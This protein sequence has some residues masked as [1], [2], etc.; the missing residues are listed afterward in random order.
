MRDPSRFAGDA[1]ILARA[2]TASADN[3]AKE[4]SRRLGKDAQEVR[5]NSDRLAVGGRKP[6]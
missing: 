5:L 1:K 2:G 6:P 3:I 4:H